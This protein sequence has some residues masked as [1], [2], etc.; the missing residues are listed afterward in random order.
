M[1]RVIKK[2][3]RINFSE[4]GHNGFHYPSENNTY[5]VTDDV[6]A[7]LLLWVTPP[8]DRVPVKV[9]LPDED[10]CVFWV[11]KTSFRE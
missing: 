9:S 1:T 10:A 8:G 5:I 2:G 11:S 6:E 7:K 3:S 4:I